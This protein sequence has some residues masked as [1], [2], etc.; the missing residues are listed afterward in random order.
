MSRAAT[1]RPMDEA[2]A[3][4][5]VALQ[6]CEVCGAGQYPPRDLCRVCLS[7]QMAWTTADTVAGDLLC[8]TTVQHSFVPDTKLPQPIGLVRLPMGETA[9]CLL[10]PAVQPGAVTIRASLDP[11]GRAVLRALPC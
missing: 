6:H 11:A 7:D 10:D 9:I 2:A 3:A 5:H 1:M 8:L 4:G